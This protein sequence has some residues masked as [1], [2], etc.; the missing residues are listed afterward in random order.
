MNAAFRERLASARAFVRAPASNMLCIAL[1]AVLLLVAAVAAGADQQPIPDLHAR[2]TD[3]TGTLAAAQTQALESELAAL[4]QRKGAQVAVLIVP[5][6]QPEDIAQ[7]AIR[8]FDQWKLGRQN[9]DDGVLLVVAKD[10]HRVRIEVARGL[11]GAIPD[12]AASRIIREYITPKFR[13]GDFDGGIEDAVGALTKLIDGEALPPPLENEQK[14]R[15]GRPDTAINTLIMV[16]FVS[17]W[18]RS[19]VGRLS[20]LPRAGIVGTIGGILAMFF[21]GVLLL[22]LVAA[23]LAAIIGALGGGGGGFA[24]RGG[25]GGFG[26]GGFGGGG[27]GGGGFGG[28]GF[29]GGGGMSA[30]GGASGSW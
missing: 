12:A 25:W 22:A 8:V 13:A 21:G 30:G 5:T 28:G 9:I 3:T 17:I 19:M 20:L 24:R 10:D 26:G 18:L 6:T 16:V 15:R 11:E 27:F 23:V 7:Y 1:A 2:V 4:E 14:A 29:S